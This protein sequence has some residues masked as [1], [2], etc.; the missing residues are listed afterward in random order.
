MPNHCYNEIVAKKEILDE[1]YDYKE[2]KIDFNKLIPMPKELENSVADGSGSI[3]RAMYL[4]MNGDKELL[5]AKWEGN[6]DLK[7]RYKTFNNMVDKLF[8][9]YLEE[10]VRRSY[11]CQ[12]K[13]GT[14]N[15]YDWSIKHWGTKWNAYDGVGT[16]NEKRLAFFTAWSPPEG[17]VKALCEKYPNSDLD[18]YYEE[19][20]M[21][22]AGHFYA[23]ENGEVID[24]PCPVPNYDS[25]EEDDMEF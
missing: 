8:E 9:K 18:W 4:Y 5:E 24:E 3:K 13:Y 10:E 14:D 22:F 23:G 20:G 16:P 12:E 17:I 6:K 11:E 19:P 21:D 7:D 25:E 15:W 1:L 2:K